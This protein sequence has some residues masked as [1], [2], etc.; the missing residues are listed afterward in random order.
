V[1]CKLTLVV[2]GDMETIPMGLLLP[3][4]DEERSSCRPRRI[5]H[6]SFLDSAAPL[7][8]EE[9]LPWSTIAPALQLSRTDDNLGRSSSAAL[10]PSSNS[11]SS[12]MMTTTTFLASGP[13][14]SSAKL[15]VA[16]AAAAAA[17]NNNI[18]SNHGA[19]LNAANCTPLPPPAT[20]TA[21]IAKASS[22][23][24]KFL[25]ATAASM[26]AGTPE[27]IP[28]QRQSTRALPK[29]FL[30]GPEVNGFAYGYQGL[31][32]EE[33]LVKPPP[34][35][36][37][38]AVAAAQLAADHESGAAQERAK[39]RQKATWA[40]DNHSFIA[41]LKDFASTPGGKGTLVVL[42]LGIAYT[43]YN[44][45]RPA[46]KPKKRDSEE[47]EEDDEEGPDG[48]EPSSRPSAGRA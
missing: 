30:A 8:L 12:A 4:P 45:T 44:S 11:K 33:R 41:M 47:E 42:A 21:F 38:K 40:N 31:P 27:K 24:S 20:T 46:K 37:A 39:A 10:P 32:E 6:F 13:P 36:V 43:A 25:G 17:D 9:A 48:A 1:S 16:T 15:V 18:N 26:L 22:H 7:P 28:M 29:E 34:G 5:D 35:P 2:A 19:F 23:P 3:F 14:P